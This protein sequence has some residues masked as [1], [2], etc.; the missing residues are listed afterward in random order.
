MMQVRDR[1]G[2]IKRKYGYT[3]PVQESRKAVRAV[4]FVFDESRRRPTS[5]LLLY[6]SNL[7]RGRCFETQEI[8]V[9]RKVFRHWRGEIP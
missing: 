9:E 7:V 5:D 8:R 1:R 2:V 6:A 3:A 4:A